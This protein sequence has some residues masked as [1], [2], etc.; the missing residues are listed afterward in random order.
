MGVSRA[1]IG[2][3]ARWRAWMTAEPS[4]VRDSVVFEAEERRLVLGLADGQEQ[5]EGAIGS[6]Q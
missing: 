6:C 5:P 4:V 2:L 1:A 3:N